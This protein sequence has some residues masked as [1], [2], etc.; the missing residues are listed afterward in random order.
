MNE[1][2][3]NYIRELSLKDYKTLSQKALKTVEEVGELAKVVLPYE[4][5][6][7]TNHRFIGKEKIL[8]ECSDTILCALS[9]IYSLKYSDSE[10][11]EMLIRKSGKWAAIQHSEAKC[12]KDSKFSLPFE[13][14]VTIRRKNPDT[15][16]L[17][18]LHCDKFGLKAIELEN[19]GK[20][21]VEVDLMTESKFYGNNREAYDRLK[22]ISSALKYE[23][24]EIIREKIETVP[25]HPA[26]PHNNGPVMEMSEDGYF[27]AHLSYDIPKSK[28]KEILNCLKD[29]N[30]LISK[31][32]NKS[33]KENIRLFVTVRT[34]TDT[35]EVFS[36][37]VEN[38]KALIV[39]FVGEP[40][41]ELHE[42]SIFDTNLSHDAKWIEGE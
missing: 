41:G 39:G 2:L 16:M 15:K 8:E 28:Y 18:G 13:M 33:D 11:E 40:V 5:A 27:E 9:I 22:Q 3:L 25:W 32:V 34:Y 26:S 17:F 14:H 1:D 21:F 31:S 7:G 19:I 42:Y 36:K 37:N 4:N 29:M 24:F 6:P 30:C 35:Y 12:E 20:D 10:L 38:E 23:G